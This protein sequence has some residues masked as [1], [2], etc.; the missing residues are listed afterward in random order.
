MK[1][2]LHH[3]AVALRKATSVVVCAHVRPDGDAI[4]SV[5]ALT[6]ALREMGVPAIPTLADARP[7]PAT[8]SWLPGFA[9]YVPASDLEVPSVFVALDTPIPDRLGQ[10]QA[11]AEQAGTL[12]VMDHHPDATRFGDIHVLS[13]EM[14]ATGQIVWRLLETLDVTP[15]PEIALCCYAALLTDTGRFQ[16]QN[17]TPQA[18]RDAADMIEAGVDP[19]EAARL[20]YHNRSAA[21]LALEAR[22][23]SRLTFA[24]DGRVVYSWVT[25]AD[26]DET[27]ALPE[28]AETLPDTV[29]AVAGIDVAVLMRERGDEVRVNLRAKNSFDVG[30]VARRFGGGGHPAA[31]GFT[32]NT[33]GVESLVPELLPLLPG[34]Q[35]LR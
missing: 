20:I 9:L 34:G 14:A 21:S 23:M 28:E 3:V 25:D 17:T 27:R 16:Y 26:F 10:A 33:P 4:G 1:A 7:A 31:A 29:R 35:A 30:A 2:D 12:V 15:T 5:L 6:L 24:N 32:W 19:S 22:A 8:Y 13:T 11:I 18:L